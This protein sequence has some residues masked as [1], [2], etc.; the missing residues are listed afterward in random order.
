MSVSPCNFGGLSLLSA[1][2]ALPHVGAWHGE[3]EADC[4]GREHATGSDGLVA[5]VIDGVEF[6][7]S[8]LR[9][10]DIG[11]RRKARVVGGHGG[12]GTTLEATHYTE[13]T[14]LS[15]IRD[16][17]ADCGETLSSTVD[18][19]ALDATALQSWKAAQMPASHLLTRLCSA[20]GRIWR[21]LE[22]G[23]VWVGAEDYPELAVPN[24][25]IDEDWAA[26]CIEIAPDAPN[27]VPG[28]TFLGQQIRYV[29]HHLEGDGLRTEAFLETPG[30]LLDRFLAGV[31]QEV[32]YSRLYPA[33]VVTQNADGT[34]QLLPD[35]ERVRG[36]GL[37]RVPIRCGLPGFEVRVKAGARV[38]LGFDGGDP[39]RPFASLWDADPSVVESISF[40]GG[41]RPIARVGDTVQVFAGQ[42]AIMGTVVIGEVPQPIGPGS[43]V[44][45]L[46]P[47]P[48]VVGSGN[49]K[50]LA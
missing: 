48:G 14:A 26:G 30:G 21:V 46:A 5:I 19:D 31:R 29:V 8:V 24:Q 10:V 35:D 20:I 13:T 33:E 50:G 12:L 43:F 38:R 23:T 40:A 42:T 18:S 39:S 3:L 11:G 17:L 49:P 4:A 1:R 36:A 6:R 2:I 44:T 15:V 25:L 34:L 22:D 37:D 47:L 9:S 28:V 16:I 27:L 41:T 45:F 32:I 7:C